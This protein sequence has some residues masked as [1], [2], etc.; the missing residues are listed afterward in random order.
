MRPTHRITKKRQIF[1][2]DLA[3]V[4]SY[5]SVQ[6]EMMNKMLEIAKAKKKKFDSVNTMQDI[7]KEQKLNSFTKSIK[8]NE[9]ERVASGEEILS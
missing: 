2:I 9:K 3:R 8:I 1:F 4:D 6:L 5:Y 7:R